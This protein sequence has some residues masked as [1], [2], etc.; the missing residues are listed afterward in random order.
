LADVVER[1]ARFLAAGAPLLRH[2]RTHLGDSFSRNAY[3][4]MVNTG[5]NGV[6][7]LAFWVVAARHYSAVDVGRGSALIS[8]MTLLSAVIGINVTG[9]LTRFLP[10]TGRHT[11]RFVVSTY[12]IS[13]AIVVALTLGF[14]LLVPVWG[15]SFAGLSEPRAAAWFVV[16]VA[17]AGIFTV[18]DGVLVGLRS[19]VWVPV[20]NTVF[21]VAKLVLLV[22]LATVTPADG[23]YVSF[24]VAMAIVT[25]P[26]NGLIFGRLLR[27][28]SRFTGVG[29][30]PDRAEVWRFLA[31]DY[32]GA[33]FAF[34]AA[35]VVP[36]I[37]AAVVLPQTFAPFYI[38]WMVWGSL[39]LVPINL[40]QSLTV[41]GVVDAGMLVT[42]TRAALRRAGVILAIACSVL[43]VGAPVLLGVLGPAYI[44]A[45]PLL[46]LL[47]LTALP[48]AVL[49]VWLGVLR[50]QGRPR[51]LARV[52]LASG[53]A[54]VGSVLVGLLLDGGQLGL[55]LAPI[56][57]VGV[58]V[59]V[60]QSAV[61]AAVLPQLV[62]FLRAGDRR[63]GDRTVVRSTQPYG[64]V[65][66]PTR[67]PSPRR[68]LVALR[69]ISHRA[70]DSPWRPGAPGGPHHPT[71][72]ARVTTGESSPR[73]G[74]RS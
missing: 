74:E 46:R 52:Q 4:L 45:T 34:A 10:R 44:E 25:V 27:R 57:G 70:D 20:E 65:V 24:V 60:S 9:T 41:E 56:T 26:L 3:A 23:V 64:V 73:S 54:V 14:L 72:T 55:G 33:L 36:V 58:V 6:L 19:S 59:L 13:S 35:Y 15:P 17:L 8:A 47:A 21:G 30:S 66:R 2:L 12:W 7:G 42:Y 43:G 61:T 1:P 51:S 29:A 49:E 40:A 39:Q 5:M 69:V 22:A 62:R 16:A 67:A 37:V 38:V 11:T 32:V 50:A 48:R 31:G 63:L 53:I 71:K 68:R 28:A 18:Q